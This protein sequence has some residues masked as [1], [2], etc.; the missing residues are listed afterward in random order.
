MSERLFFACQAL[1]MHL[2]DD[3]ALTRRELVC[4]VLPYSA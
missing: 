3:T 2:S 4:L 1:K